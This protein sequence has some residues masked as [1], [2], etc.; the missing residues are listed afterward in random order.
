[1]V[2]L[3]AG[4]CYTV[5]WMIAI[6]FNI[7]LVFMY[8]SLFDPKH[9]DDL[10]NTS[11]QYY[12]KIPLIVVSLI[13]FGSVFI[14]ETLRLVNIIIIRASVADSIFSVV[15]L[16]IICCNIS[17]MIAALVYDDN[18]TNSKG[19]LSLFAIMLG[20]LNIV[21][22]FMLIVILCSQTRPSV[23]SMQPVPVIAHII[24]TSTRPEVV[25]NNDPEDIAEC[26]ICLTNNKNVVYACGHYI[27]CETCNENLFKQTQLCLICSQTVNPMYKFNKPVEN[28][29]KAAQNYIVCESIV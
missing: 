21:T 27:C 1:M 5:Y 10:V 18:T 8:A 19:I 12:V 3:T 17:L 28:Y 16:T 20:S 6:L 13:L 9:T 23:P 11:V 7:I 25:F 4:I 26:S 24:W 15:I 22:F 14:F 2:K 29:N